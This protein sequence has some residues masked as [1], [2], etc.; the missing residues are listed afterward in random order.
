MMSDDL[1]GGEAFD[2]IV[3][4]SGA[5]GSAF[6]ARLAKGGK[7]VLILEAGPERRREEL[8]SSALWARRLKWNGAPV[9]EDGENPV[10]HAFN[11]SFGVGGAAMHHYA[12]W[13]RLHEEDFEMS[14]RYG[15]GMD[16]PVSYDDLR[17]Y[18]DIA[19]EEAGISGDATAESWRPA[20]APYPMPAVPLFAQGRIIARG[21]ERVGKTVAP[22]PLAVTSES[23]RGRPP[24]LWDG[25]CDAGCPIGA[26][27]NPLTIYLPQALAHGAVLTT[28]TP[29]TRVLTNDAGDIVTGVVVRPNGGPEQ[30]L[31]AE[32]VVLAAFAI[33]NPRLLLAS[34]NDSHPAG[35]GNR[36]G[37][38]GR[39]V[40]SHSAALVYGMFDEETRYYEGAFGG[41]LLN[42]DCYPKTTHED[43][44]AFGSYQWMVANAVKPN[45]LLGVATTRADLF[46]A[47]LDD[48]M[49]KATHGF[50]SMTAV[51]EG[52]PVESNRVTLADERDEFG[53]PLARVTHSH[54][55]KSTALWQAALADGKKIFNA[56][57]AREVWTGPQGAMHI[58]GG[59][60]MGNDAKSSVAN[61]FGEVHDIA[62]LYIAGPGLFPTSGGVNPTFTVNALAIRAADHVLADTSPL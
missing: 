61:E 42:Q 10:G 32:I 16:W 19:Q 9:I 27:A 30:V 38:V 24:C 18:Y 59:T 23:Y 28:D 41:Q 36:H 2:A 22:L 15:I 49:Q 20:G 31:R 45:D 33:Q 60:V 50:A 34:A 57:G 4:G 52:L 25:W 11:A 47:E 6:A 43:A 35:L 58:M 44:G 40:M 26:L 21:F 53:V 13:P 48:F 14:S 1:S 37:N 62:N 8:V 46:G 51:V 56:A 55:P 29:V 3:V 5:A 7:K 12:V 39:Y 54:H 17:P